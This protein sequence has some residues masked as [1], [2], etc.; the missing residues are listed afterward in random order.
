MAS[1]RATQQALIC[2]CIAGIVAQEVS[3]FKRFPG[4]KCDKVSGDAV[5]GLSAIRCLARAQMKKCSDTQ[6]H[7]ACQCCDTIRT[8]DNST[9]IYALAC[10]GKGVWNPIT[11]KCYYVRKQ[12]KEWME[13]RTACRAEGF[14]LVT[15]ENGAENT[16]VF[17][18]LSNPAWIG[19]NDIAN[20]NTFV[21]SDGSHSAYTNWYPGQPNDFENQDCIGMNWDNY[22]EKWADHECDHGSMPEYVCTL[23]INP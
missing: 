19:L 12:T 5:E 13:A 14:E 16:F 17:G 4:F 9:A 1:K 6:I 3:R 8:G 21:W 7:P 20:E 22:G 18:L 10:P 2:F 23:K 15:I 11:G